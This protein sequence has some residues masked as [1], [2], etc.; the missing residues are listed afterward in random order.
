[1]KTKFQYYVDYKVVGYQRTHLV[2]EAD[3]KEEADAK[4]VEVVQ[5][6]NQFEDEHFLENETLFETFEPMSLEQSNGHS[7]EELFDQEDATIWENG[8]SLWSQV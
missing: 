1:M 7:T 5:A 8:T 2:I 3:S 4:A 6:G